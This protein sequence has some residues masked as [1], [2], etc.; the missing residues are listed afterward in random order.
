MEDPFGTT[1][2][3][4]RETLEIFENLSEDQEGYF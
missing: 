4:Y 3:F 2:F 1:H